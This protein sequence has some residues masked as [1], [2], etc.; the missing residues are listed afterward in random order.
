MSPT[1]TVPVLIACAHGTR[2]ADGQQCV[3]QLRA[4]VA[5]L[6]PELTVLQAYVDVQHPALPE[7]VAALP[8]GTPAVVVPLLLSVGHHVRVDIAR[9]VAARPELN[10]AAPLGPDPRLARLLRERLIAAGLQADDGVVLAAAGSSV[11]DADDDVREMAR[12]LGSLIPHRIVVGYGASAEP[13]VPEAVAGLR[14][15]GFERVIIASYLLAP[16]FFHQQLLKAGADAVA[17]PLLPGASSSGDSPSGMA[18]LVV[19]RYR[20]ALSQ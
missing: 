1:T 12:L 7:V 13:A 19:E 5:A 10:A 8:A 6:Q 9:A 14:A 17:E 3:T 18:E 11:Q 20:A 15:E 2:S 4:E 16:G